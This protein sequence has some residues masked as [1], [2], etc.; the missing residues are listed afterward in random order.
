MGILKKKYTKQE[1]IDMMEDYRVQYESGILTKSLDDVVA[2]MYEIIDE[3]I[4][5]LPQYKKTETSEDFQYADIRPLLKTSPDYC[6]LYGQRSNGKSFTILLALLITYAITGYKIDIV[7]RFKDSFRGKRGGM[8]MFEAFNYYEVV[9]FFTGGK[10]NK[11]VYKSFEFYFQKV[12]KKK[13]LVQDLT[14]FAIGT[15]IF[16]Q[17]DDKGASMLEYGN[18]FFDEFIPTDKRYLPDEFRLFANACSTVIRNRSNVRIYM[19]AN[20][21]DP[22]CIY[23]KELGLFNVKTQQPGELHTYILDSNKE[24]AVGKVAI[25]RTELNEISTQTSSKYF[26][27]KNPNVQAIFNGEWVQDL[28]PRAPKLNIKTPDIVFKFYIYISDN[29]FIS[30]DEEDPRLKTTIQGDV[31]QYENYDYIVF[32]PLKYGKEPDFE[33]DFIFSNRADGRVNWHSKISRPTDKVSRLIAQYFAKDKVFYSSDDIH[34]M[35]ERY[36]L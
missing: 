19:A 15:T 22:D 29:V 23:F 12:D 36:V 4:F 2:E 1:I 28:S 27:V 32:H 24:A 33:N 25:L 7:K 5:R 9:E 26:N 3:Y 18:I 31:I 13:I 35:I 10:F 8:K 6:I 16:K 30:L 34:A 17:D 20:A 11:I 14:P 21:L